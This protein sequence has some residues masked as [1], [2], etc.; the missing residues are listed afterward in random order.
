MKSSDVV[1]V[2]AG[3]YGLST[4]AHLKTIPGLNVKT[5]GEPLALWKHQMPRGMYLR[6][7]LS[8]SHIAHPT[9]QYTMTEYATKHNISLSKPLT[10]D[11]FVG[12][13]DWYQKNLVSDLDRRNVV[14][15]NREGEGFVVT[16]DDGETMRTGRVIVAAGPGPFKW[17]PPEFDAFPATHASHSSD[18]S[19]LS[20]FAG[21]RIFVVGAGQSAL[22][23]TAILNEHGAKVELV[24]RKPAIHWLRWKGRLHS[25]YPLGKI[26]YSPR[27]VGPAGVSQIIARP[28]LFRKMPRRFQDWATQRSVN[29]AGAL[30]LMDRLKD[31]PARTGVYP[32]GGEMVGN[33]IRVTL[34]D[35]SSELVDHIMFSTGFRVDLA[36]YKFLSPE[37][38]GKIERV[39]GYPRLGAALES[40]V[41]GLHFLGAP[42]GWSY[43]PLARFVSGTFYSPAAVTRHII[44]RN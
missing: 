41:R 13:G 31:V 35:G 10:L 17:R 20:K 14:S 36:R 25:L 9:G 21:K 11:S 43:G 15:I 1:I 26:L 44:S 37:L 12:Y 4:A 38:L 32:K 16:A 34:S 6:S 3:P 18:H 28:D 40:S 8:A 5:F 30:W 27:D 42:S 22:E 24:V 23:N 7:P 19:D 33:Q 29:P 39:N 2:G